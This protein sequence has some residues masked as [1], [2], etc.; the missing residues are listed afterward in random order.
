MFA[1]EKVR[2]KCF[3]REDFQPT[4]DVHKLPDKTK[5]NR[6]YKLL[7]EMLQCHACYLFCSDDFFDV[8]GVDITIGGDDS[9]GRSQY[10]FNKQLF[11]FL[12]INQF[13][14]SDFFMFCFLIGKF[15]MILIIIRYCSNKEPLSRLF[16]LAC[17]DYKDDI[18]GL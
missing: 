4:V 16:H 6:W 1:S 15:R 8:S 14:L 10:V 13:Y 17:V 3:S 11:T 9:K 18:Q 2:C 5:V 7:H 12:N